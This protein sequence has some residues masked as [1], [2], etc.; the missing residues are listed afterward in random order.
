[1]VR[2]IIAIATAIAQTPN[3]QSHPRLV[4][5]HTKNV[6]PSD[7]PNVTENMY[8]L[9]KLERETASFGSVSSN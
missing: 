8:Q 1:M 5:I 2:N 4:L 7:A 3:D 9:K 6:T